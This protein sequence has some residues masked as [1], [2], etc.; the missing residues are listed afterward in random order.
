MDT[1]A[2]GHE[3]TD[4]TGNTDEDAHAVR[5]FAFRSLPSVKS[6]VCFSSP[7]VL[8]LQTQYGTW[9]CSFWSFEFV[10]DFVIGCGFGALG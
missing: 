8:T 4:Y 6:V 5:S 10:S 7:A 2:N 1:D 3:T 9:F